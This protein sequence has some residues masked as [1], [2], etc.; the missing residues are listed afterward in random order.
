M[1]ITYDLI[2]PTATNLVTLDF[3]KNFLGESGQANVDEVV[4]VELIAAVSTQMAKYC[5]VMFGEHLSADFV[6]S[7][8]FPYWFQDTP[9]SKITK[10]TLDKENV[11]GSELFEADGVVSYPANGFSY[12]EFYVEYIAGY[13]LPDSTPLPGQSQ[14]VSPPIPAD[15][16]YCRYELVKDFY[17][18]RGRSADTTS[19]DISGV[20]SASFNSFGG[21]P[22]I[23]SQILNPYRKIEV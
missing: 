3:I 16:K 12:Q 18:A 4:L 22:R 23:A 21:I 2:G 8:N 17:L 15:L 13:A 7:V 6:R 20:V 1:I 9:V 14:V 10:A 5:N 19:E 11:L